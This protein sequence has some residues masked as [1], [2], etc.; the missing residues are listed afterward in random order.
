MC[1][2]NYVTKNNHAKLNPRFFN[3]MRAL[4]SD[5]TLTGMVPGV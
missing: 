3:A 4:A 5:I 1:G 2:F